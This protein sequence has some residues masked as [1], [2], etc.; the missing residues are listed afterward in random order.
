MAGAMQAGH[1][2][3]ALHQP[4]LPS[5][6][7]GVRERFPELTEVVEQTGAPPLDGLARAHGCSVLAGRP[8]VDWCWVGTERG[9][10]RWGAPP[11]CAASPA[12]LRLLPSSTAPAC[13]EPLQCSAPCAHRLPSGCSAA[14]PHQAAQPG[15]MSAA[16]QAAR[17]RTHLLS[18][19]PYPLHPRCHLAN[20][21]IS[22]CCAP[23]PLLPG[24][25]IRLAAPPAAAIR[26]SNPTAIAI[27]TAPSHL[28]PFFRFA[29]ARPHAH[30]IPCR[31]EARCPTCTVRLQP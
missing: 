4:H 15:A 13:R 26:C 17:S 30:P 2:T 25:L 7:P 24:S 28:P 23:C 20:A 27:G 3:P 1:P 11:P 5:I 21:A 31:F 8:A 9:G 14:Q 12:E 29:L 10:G 19:P 6:I 16:Q 18:L 22:A